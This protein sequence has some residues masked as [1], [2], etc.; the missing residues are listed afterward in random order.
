MNLCRAQHRSGARETFEKV[1]HRLGH[2]HLVHAIR[3]V[4]LLLSVPLPVGGWELLAG[5]AVDGLLVA[6]QHGG[7]AVN[8]LSSQCGWGPSMWRTSKQQGISSKLK[9]CFLARENWPGLPGTHLLQPGDEAGDASDTRKD[10]V[11]K[12]QLL[13]RLYHVWHSSS[14]VA[15]GVQAGSSSASSCTC[16]TSWRR[17]RIRMTTTSQPSSLRSQLQPP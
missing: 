11:P 4:A 2:R 14:C 8:L 3:R 17:T 10:L 1:L 13:G 7:G 5:L 6:L 16:G 9:I 12:Q 15:A